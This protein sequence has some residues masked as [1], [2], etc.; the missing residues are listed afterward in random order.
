VVNETQPERLLAMLNKHADE[1]RPPR[2]TPPA[3]DQGI[4]IN[5]ELR[6]KLFGWNLLPIE[7][8][9]L[10]SSKDVA[11]W[12]GLD[13]WNDERG[14]ARGGRKRRSG[15][16]RRARRHDPNGRTD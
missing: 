11:E 13:W 7:V 5:G 16:R 2:R 3:L 12:V 14:R 9:L 6:V 1:H 4:A 15:D 8:K 10:I